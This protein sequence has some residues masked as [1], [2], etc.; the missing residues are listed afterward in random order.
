MA[1]KLFLIFSVL[2]M[3]SVRRFSFVM[4]ERRDDGKE[5][6]KDQGACAVLHFDAEEPDA[7]V[8]SLAK[9]LGAFQARIVFVGAKAVTI[10]TEDDEGL[11][12]P[13]PY[14]CLLYTSPSPRDA[15]LSRMPSSA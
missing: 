10:A 12:K 13:L 4:H 14:I 5:I 15:T 7:I 8:G 6:S 3:I 2:R 11:V 1:D 9:S